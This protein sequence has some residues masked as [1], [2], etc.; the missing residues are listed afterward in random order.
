MRLPARSIAVLT[1][2]ALL[3][4][5]AGAVSKSAA[6]AAPDESGVARAPT[7]DVAHTT[8]HVLVLH[9]KSIH[10]QATAGT[11]TLRD[12]LG[13]PIASMFYIAYTVPPAKGY[14][15]RPVTFLFN[16]GPGSAS[17][18]LNIGGFGPMRAVTE[19]PGNTP[20]PPYSFV[21]NDDSLL[22]KTDLVFLD[23]IGTGY[24]RVIG[25]GSDAQFW[26]VDGDVDSFAKGI[27]RYIESN[28]RWNSPK[29]LYGESYGTTRAAALAYALHVEDIDVSGVILQSSILNFARSSPGLD[30]GYIDLLPSYAAAAWYHHRVADAPADEMAFLKQVETFARGPYAQAL[31][32]GDQLS[33]QE[34]AA[35]AR[36]VSDYTGLPVEYVERSHLRVEME[37]FRRE[38]LRGQGLVIGRFDS[39]Y[40]WPAVETDGH[41]NPATDDPATAAVNGPYL[42]AFRVAL[43]GLDYST[44]LE[45]RALYN[46]V[47]EPRWNWHHIAPGMDEPLTS[48]DTALDLAAV[49]AANPNLK[50]L[51]LNGLYDMS[52]PFFGTEFDLSHML[53][54]QSVSRNITIKYYASGHQLYSNPRV[55]DEM[56]GDLDR[57]YDEAPAH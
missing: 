3:S 25:K 28:H 26:S 19:K 15:E 48:P 7:T 34:E 22:D 8:D 57:F 37:S 32:A 21:P 30:E 6:A 4:G 10:Y 24:S 41:F 31:A 44:S 35:V 20:A 5:A 56:T 50:V 27:A 11:L 1:M 23:A 16:G 47:I 49:M 17:L 43:D 12:H 55:L 51:S 33:P 45:Y 39:R 52:T 42:A 46:Q 9:G 54:P 36:Q 38:L 40:A 53:L 14:S 29:F 18:W 13:E 2:L